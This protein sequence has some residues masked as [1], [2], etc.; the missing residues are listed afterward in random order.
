MPRKTIVE[1]FYSMRGRV[2]CRVRVQS[3]SI[4]QERLSV[5]RNAVNRLE[6]TII[7]NAPRKRGRLRRS[8]RSRGSLAGKGVTIGAGVFYAPFQERGTR[9]I[10]ARYFMRKALRELISSLDTNQFDLRLKN[11]RG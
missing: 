3:T 8:I 2:Y 1:V 10:R 4:P 5:L 11:V 9:F 7:R 6:K